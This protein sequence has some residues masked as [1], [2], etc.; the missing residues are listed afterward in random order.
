MTR[1]FSLSACRA[2]RLTIRSPESGDFGEARL[3]KWTEYARGHRELARVDAIASPLNRA[4]R[5]GVNHDD[6]PVC[7]Y[8]DAV[9]DGAGSLDVHQQR[10]A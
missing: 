7:G 2:R 10:L 3:T 9:D 8:G 4:S 1:S 6:P 5:T